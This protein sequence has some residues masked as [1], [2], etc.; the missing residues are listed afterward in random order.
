MLAATETE[1]DHIQGYMQSQAPDLTVDFLQKVYSEI[2]GQVR[3][4]IWDVHTGGGRW[5]VITSPTNLYSQDDFPNMDLALTFHIGLCIRIPRSEKQSISSLPAEPF[6]QC[7]RD[8]QEATEALSHAE[9]VADFQAVGVRCREA[10]LAFVSVA[11]AILP[12]APDPAPKK[13]DL[14]PWVTYFCEIALR[15]DSQKTRR[16]LLKS[17]CFSV[18]RPIVK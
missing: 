4:D 7:F 11:Q 8:L 15:G 14:K 18:V 9:E 10:L 2:V 12:T 13:A 1:L 6:G 3:H 5:W 16:Q 17:I